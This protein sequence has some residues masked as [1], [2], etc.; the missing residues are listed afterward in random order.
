MMEGSYL[1]SSLRYVL[2]QNS[3]SIYLSV[4]RVRVSP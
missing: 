4:A 2:R 1:P 3:K